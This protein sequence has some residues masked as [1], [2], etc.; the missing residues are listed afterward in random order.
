LHNLGEEAVRRLHIIVA[1]FIALCLAAC[2]GKVDYI[3]P[4]SQAAPSAN[5]KVIAKPRAAVWSASVPELGKQFF[6]SNNLDKSSGLINVSY[7]GYRAVTAQDLDL[8]EWDA[9]HPTI[10]LRTF[11]SYR[12][13]QSGA[14]VLMARL[15]AALRFCIAFAL[16]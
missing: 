15:T 6:V 5:A 11:H 9:D 10:W 8:I 14:S 2:A 16:H 4:A 1:T 3:R 7:N 12:A 13:P